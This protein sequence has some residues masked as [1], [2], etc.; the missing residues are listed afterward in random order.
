M[1]GKTLP[2]L[3]EDAVDCSCAKEKVAGLAVARMA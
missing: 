3:R 2:Q 1:C